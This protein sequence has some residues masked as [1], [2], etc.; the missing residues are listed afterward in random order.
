MSGTDLKMATEL[1]GRPATR[2][3]ATRS[4]M[5]RPGGCPTAL[6]RWESILVMLLIAVIVG[7]TLVSPY[8]LDLYNLAD[9]TYNFSEKAIIA[10]AMALLILVREIDLSVAAI[11]ALA[12][13][14]HRAAGGGGV[15]HAGALRCG[16]GG[17]DWRAAP[18]TVLLVTR[19]RRALHRRS[20]SAPCRCFAV[21]RR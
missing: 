5:P 3:R 15:W 7:N 1:I 17:R 19:I 9:A 18:S 8:F 2:V 11:I 14:V 10:L 16:A 6:L 13:L 20:P 4:P 21:S 12:S